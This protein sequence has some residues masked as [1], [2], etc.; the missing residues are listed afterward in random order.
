MAILVDPPSVRR[1]GARLAA[2]A[3]VVFAT[4]GQP[5]PI[6][7][8][9]AVML[10]QDPAGILDYLTPER[11]QQARPFPLPQAPP[12]SLRWQGLAPDEAGAPRG[13]PMVREG[14]G[15]TGR[16]RPDPT[17]RL[18][19]PQAA[20]DTSTIEP[21]LGKVQPQDAGAGTPEA[22]YSSSRLIPLSADLSY[23]Y[24]AVGTLLVVLPDTRMT[25]CSGAVI[26]YRLVLTAGHCVHSGTSAGYHA[27][28]AFVPAYRDGTAPFGVWPA[29]AWMTTAAWITGHGSFPNEADYAL[30]EV[31]DQLIGGRSMRLGEVVGWLGVRAQGLAIK[32]LVYLLGYPGNLDNTQKMHQVVSTYYASLAPNT[33]MYGSDMRQGSS[34][35]PWVENF[36]L[37]AVGQ[38]GG[39]YPGFN[40]VIG[41]T[42]YGFNDPTLRV[43]GSSILDNRF[44]TELLIPACQHQVGNC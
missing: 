23:P 20:P 16:V 18:F 41:V 24:S 28:F 38:L 9:D 30:I 17:R 31:A 5:A 40:Q 2:F 6:G 10:E 34:G 15:P 7:A 13:L 4:W 19:E 25:R 35:G 22:V 21:Q 29:T 33:V 42:S 12:S 43:Q 8:A 44:F 39:L 36:G 26:A 37:P 11:L 27:H 14:H 32:N 3:A 1:T